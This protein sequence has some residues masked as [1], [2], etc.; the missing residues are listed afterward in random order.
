MKRNKAQPIS[1]PRGRPRSFDRDDALERAMHVFWE[2]GYEATSI[3]QLTAAMGIN[4]PSLYA[5]FGDKEKLFLAVVDRYQAGPA[6][7]FE[8][9]LADEPTARGAVEMLLKVAAAELTCETHP[10]GCL[11]VLAAATC[12]QESAG[13]QASLVK[14]RAYMQGKLKARFEKAIRNG[15]LP[16]SVNA[17]V[18]AQLY[19]T[20]LQG[21]SIQAK[22]GATCDQLMSVAKAAMQAWPV[23]T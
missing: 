1:K 15:E 8:R 10:P 9:A 4:P 21:M 6:D 13:V 17:D 3:S 23:R 7:E 5:A 18:L 12:S 20:I 11:V 14:L 19:A 2:H 16:K 22:D